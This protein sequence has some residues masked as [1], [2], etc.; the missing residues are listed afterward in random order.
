M[1]GE[2]NYIKENLNTVYGNIAKAAAESGRKAEEITLITVTKTFGIDKILAAYGFGER[3]YGENRV[4]EL[5]EKY[6]LL[7]NQHADIKWH[8][9]GHLQTNKVKYII[10]K[11]KLIHSVE[12]LSLA[13]EINKRAAKAE[14]V[15]DVLV[16]LNVSGEESKFGIPP[17]N[18]M[19]F[20]E[21]MLEYKNIAVK[22]LMTVAPFVEDGEENREIFSKMRKLYIDINRN[23]KDNIHMEYLS[24]GMTGDYEAAIKEGANMVR[25]GTGIFG[26]RY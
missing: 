13:E 19:S 8:L 7:Q 4:Q 6:D 1:I 14:I 12:S 15:Q 11:T 16:E 23:Y 24:M 2:N 26:K 18:A 3:N 9:I 10:G 22:G 21:K 25:V 17:Q 20:V 5:T